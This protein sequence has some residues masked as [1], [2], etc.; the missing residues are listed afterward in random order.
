MYRLYK[1]LLIL[2][3]VSTL[4]N[5]TFA[6][7]WIS[8]G[9]DRGGMRHS[10]LKQIT[11]ENVHQLE[12]AWEYHTGDLAAGRAKIIECTPVIIDGDMPHQR[13]TVWATGSLSS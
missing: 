10:T 11:R 3:L 7:D 5:P 2:T 8:V 13:P 6:E 4:S 12:V 9:G 1:K